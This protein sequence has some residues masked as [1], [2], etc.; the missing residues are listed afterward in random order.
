M[1]WSDIRIFLQVAREGA[2]ARA[3]TALEMDHSTISRRISRLERE[4]GAP[5][6]E[7]A[8]RRLVL[9][10]EGDKMVLAAEKLESIILREVLCLSEQSAQIAGPVRVGA[11]EEFGAHYLARRLPSV[12]AR[13]PELEIE[14]VA[15]S[16]HLSLAGREADILIT[17]TRPVTGDLKFKK[18]VD[19]AYG[20]YATAAYRAR[21]SLERNSRVEDLGDE[22]WCAFSERVRP[23]GEGK[24]EGEA[25][26]AWEAAARY[27]TT[28]VS[29]QLQAV[30]SGSALA[31]LPCF[32]AADH[33][34]LECLAS[35]FS[36]SDQSYW[37]AVHADMARYPR[38]RA[39]MDAIDA[40]V[41]RDRRLFGS[42]GGPAP[43]SAERR[44]G[45]P[46]I[47]AQA[48][49]GPASA[50]SDRGGDAL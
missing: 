21:R 13:H 8:G 27:R 30:L 50:L 15:T 23:G 5:L 49:S 32:V 18:L 19:L 14:L 4:A 11:A 28:S 47:L 22:V 34:Q 9:T 16:R 39:V 42:H 12:M 40:E 44:P 3:T 45:R 2:M 1:E 46:G 37:M 48:L 20:V 38:I 6:F 7:R 41:T 25:G 33:P 31:V 24:G 17:P 26:L 36:G 35:H 29:V 43:S 10:A